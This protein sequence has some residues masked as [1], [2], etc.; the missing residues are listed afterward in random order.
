M[1][2][3]ELTVKQRDALQR[4]SEFTLVDALYGRRSRRFPV[5]GE[6]PDGPLAYRSEHDPAPLSEL[7]RL[8]V[9][10]ACAGTTGWHYAIMRHA[11]YAPHLANYAGGAAG[12]TFPSAAGFHTAEIFLTD[13][14]GTYF[15]PT[16]DAGAL[17]D[18]ADEELTPELLVE[19]HASRLRRLS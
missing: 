18:P 7:E 13:D 12:R 1:A 10:T 15:F 8:L 6:I 14:S 4:L 11:R 3:V 9:L 17:V 19:R 2:N 5:G 16:R